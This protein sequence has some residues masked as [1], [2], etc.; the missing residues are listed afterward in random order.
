MTGMTTKRMNEEGTRAGTRWVTRKAYLRTR[1]LRTGVFVP[2][3]YLVGYA[4]RKMRTQ[5]RTFLLVAY[6]PVN[7]KKFRPGGLE[8][9]QVRGVRVLGKLFAGI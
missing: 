6:I 7:N 4:R 9:T 2:C 5:V 8:S 1:V 3:L